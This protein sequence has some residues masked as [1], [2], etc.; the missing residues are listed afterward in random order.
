M[1][2]HGTGAGTL[3]AHFAG[4]DR[5][6]AADVSVA[7]NVMPVVGGEPGPTVT[8]STSHST[9]M[10]GDSVALQW[11]SSNASTCWA[12]G[13]WAGKRTASGIQTVIPEDPGVFTY[14]LTC[15]GPGGWSGASTRLAVEVGG[16]DADACDTILTPNPGPGLKLRGTKDDDTIMGTLGN[17][18][19]IGRRGNDRL[20]GDD[21]QDKVVGSAGADLLCGGSGTDRLNGGPG[22]DVL[23]GGPD[24]DVLAGGGGA[25]IYNFVAANTGQDEIRGF[26]RKDWLV[27]RDSNEDGLVDS[28]D[29]VLTQSPKGTWVIFG[30]GAT[31]RVLLRGVK[32][33]V[34]QF[35]EKP[36]SIGTGTRIVL[37]RNPKQP[38]R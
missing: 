32:P 31:D 5:W 8:L 11:S 22:T 7:F 34:L 30:D 19:V 4:N 16:I 3:T 6:L 23:V 17:D 38:S 1:T 25:D 21:G 26:D 33:A 37:A 13:A 36:G 15:N 35:V 10:L 2:P 27:F 24:A 14:T 29:V 9:V 18:V 12:G 20:H 28:R